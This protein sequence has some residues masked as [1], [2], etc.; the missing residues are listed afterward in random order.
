MCDD[1]TVDFALRPGH[2][3]TVTVGA[4]GKGKARIGLDFGG[5]PKPEDKIA[6]PESHAEGSHNLWLTLVGIEGAALNVVLRST[7]ITVVIPF[8]DDH[9]L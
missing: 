5:A 7:A 4:N 2:H 9:L 8:H 6:S 3:T 1:G